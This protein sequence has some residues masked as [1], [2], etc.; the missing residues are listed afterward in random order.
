MLVQT[1]EEIINYQFLL[2]TYMVCADGQIH[3]EE[4]K[5]LHELAQKA[6]VGKPTLEEMEKILSQ[7]ED[8]VSFE[9]VVH[10]KRRN[11]S[12]IN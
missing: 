8:L 5:A 9:D 10:K 2:L 4:I 11:G 7:D 6:E 3:S 12:K 1:S